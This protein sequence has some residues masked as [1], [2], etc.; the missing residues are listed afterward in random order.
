MAL[1]KITGASA[2]ALLSVAGII[3][4][5]VAGNEPL[6]GL[7]LQGGVSVVYA[8]TEPAS[9]ETLDQT[10]EIIRERVDAIGVAEPEISR[11]GQTIVVDLPGVDEQQRA[12]DLVGQT[13][14][15]R[16]RP[17]I[18]DLGP[19]I[20]PEL[21]EQLQ[22]EAET[23]T[24]TDGETESTTTTVD[25]GAEDEQGMAAV[26]RYRRQDDSTT[27]TTDATETTDEPDT[28]DPVTED[29]VAEEPVVISPEE[30]QFL[31][32]VS[33]ACD[34]AA[35]TPPED[36]LYENYVVLDDEDGNR[37]CLGPALL[38]GDTL[39]SADV[40]F[41]GLQTWTVSPVFKEGAEGIDQFNAAAAQC[42]AASPDPIVCPSGRLAIVLDGKVISAPNIQQPSFDRD[43]IQISGS[44][45]EVS[46]RN[47][48]LVLNYGALPVVL[49]AQQT[50]T[51]SA[52]IGSD[53]LQGLCPFLS[54]VAIFTVGK[55]ATEA[56]AAV[57]CASATEDQQCATAVL[58]DDAR[59]GDGI[60]GF[61]YGIGAIAGYLQQFITV[62]EY[63]A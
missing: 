61:T 14:E 59:V 32:D 34:I 3:Y 36:D 50:R 35:T 22:N 58:L 11:Q 37:T 26:N 25:A 1:P 28:E 5:G 6:L 45:D 47:L 56:V 24:E 46:A 63:L 19:A 60:T 53:V 39:E 10:L 4:T 8:P 18:Q 49:E 48:A 42:Y 62:T 2:L 41:D 15:L 52:T 29:P 54:A 7:D 16:F 20:D 21:L 38:R 44:F 57:N 40:G 30:Q 9:D 33:A 55:V 23:E 31:D 13:A 17:V 12:L 51:V 43:Q 27:E